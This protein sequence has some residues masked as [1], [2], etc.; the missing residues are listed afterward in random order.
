MGVL[1]HLRSKDQFLLA[2]C[3]TLL[4]HAMC[5]VCEH[6]VN[7]SSCVACHQVNRK[8]VGSGDNGRISKATASTRSGGYDRTVAASTR[9]PHAKFGY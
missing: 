6:G 4:R 3:H 9:V 5:H 1:E 7:C 8:T 2:L